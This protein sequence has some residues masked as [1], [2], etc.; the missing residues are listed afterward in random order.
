FAATI[1]AQGRTLQD[2]LAESDF[3]TLHIALTPQT[4]HLIGAEALTAMKQSAYLVNTS[5][6]GVVDE[7][8][9]TEALRN[10]TLAGAALDV[11]EKEPL[12]ADDPIRRAPNL[13]LT[14][15]IAGATAEARSRS[16]RLA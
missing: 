2:L 16:S 1:G 15:H 5:R 10:G 14:P 8:A 11:L 6:G 13:L 7:G 4:R 12:A 3:V 9:L